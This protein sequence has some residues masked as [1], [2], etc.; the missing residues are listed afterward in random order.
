MI[1]PRGWNTGQLAQGIAFIALGL[2]ALLV[3][4]DVEG[5]V[6]V[7]AVG[8]ALFALV[9]IRSSSGR[10]R[11]VEDRDCRVTLA[12]LAILGAGETLGAWLCWRGSDPD[13]ACWFLI[14]AGFA[15]AGSIAAWREEPGDVT[16][17]AQL[18]FHGFVLLP[19]LA[20]ATQAAL[21]V[22]VTQ[23]VPHGAISTNGPFL[24][25]GL[26]VGSILVPGLL[27]TLAFAIAMDPGAAKGARKTLWNVLLAHEIVALVILGRWVA[28]LR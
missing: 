4:A 23:N 15:V 5:L 2:A 9:L 11:H 1:E 13:M 18:M 20:G 21:A 26:V 10:G 24:R 22:E 12:T 25:T 14:G 19:L 7:T 6:S 3:R 28:G 27:V 16:F 17:V 8:H